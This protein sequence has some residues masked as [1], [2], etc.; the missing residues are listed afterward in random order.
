M[1]ILTNGYIH[2]MCGDDIPCGFVAFECG[3]ITAVGSM[4]DFTATDTDEITDTAG[5]HISPGLID[6][7][8]HVGMWEDSMDFE[9]ADGNEDTDPI[10]PHLRGID[11]VNPLDRSFSDARLAGIT[12]VV[13]GPGSSNVMG[14]QFAALKTY[15][16]CVDEMI[17]KAPIAT[18]F[19]LGENPKTTYHNKNQTP[20]TRMAMAALLR[21]TLYKATEY[22][23][24]LD[25]YNADPDEND[26]P[27]FDI[28]LESLMPLLRKEI[29]AKVH[30]HRADDIAT[31]MRIAKEFDINITIEHCTEGHLIP[32][33][34]KAGCIPVMAGPALCERCKIELRQSGFENY[35][36]L[37]DA[38][39]CV[40]IIT[41]HPVVPIEY[42]PLCASLAVKSGMDRNT[43]LK[44]ITINAAKN[45]GIDNVVG[46]L[47]VGKDA[48]I[49]VFSAHPLDFNARVLHTFINGTDAL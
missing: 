14:G 45:C 15:G 33:I 37:T 24:A 39:L 12:T 8:C 36:K 17:I 19:S 32:H 41:D 21:E 7:H 31:A 38:G 23:T 2:T 48:D 43:A 28:K 49:A 20:V 34:L 3:K 29:H 26:K 40:A 25:E 9:G 18:K 35:K 16:C 47:A 10:T 42:L 27:E 46:S 22:K 11:S 30:A 6:A 44:A 5:A 4:G 13:T 1:K